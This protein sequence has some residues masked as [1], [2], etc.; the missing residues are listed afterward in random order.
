M[1]LTR[2]YKD[3]KPMKN[4]NEWAGPHLDYERQAIGSMLRRRS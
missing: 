2:K 4:D 1:E 3:E